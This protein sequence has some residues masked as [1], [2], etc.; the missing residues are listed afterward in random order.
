MRELSLDGWE[1]G[2]VPFTSALGRMEPGR[3]GSMINR[4]LGLGIS[5]FSAPGYDDGEMYEA[6]FNVTHLATGLKLMMISG[7]IGQVLAMIT[8]IGRLTD[9]TK[10]AP[11]NLAEIAVQVR[12]IVGAAE[13]RNGAIRSAVTPGY[14]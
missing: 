4:G 2:P 3:E 14:A 11:D 5:S 9:W 8:A 1:T 12:Q 13:W 10:E 7:N 6:I